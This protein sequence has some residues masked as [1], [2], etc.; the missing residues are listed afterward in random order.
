MCDG[1]LVEGGKRG[2]WHIT[3]IQTY[4]TNKKDT[5]LCTNIVQKNGHDFIKMLGTFT[6]K[7]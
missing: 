2:P 1:L 3:I 7:V 5:I 4:I 6:M